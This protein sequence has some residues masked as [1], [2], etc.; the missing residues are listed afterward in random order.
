MTNKI[1]GKVFTYNTLGSSGSNQIT[2]MQ[3]E[4]RAGEQWPQQFLVP[5]IEKQLLTS[6]RVKYNW[7][8]DFSVKWESLTLQRNL[9]VGS[10]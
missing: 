5:I 6:I 10:D 3:D 4:F 9:V 8:F 2:K 1:K 7:N